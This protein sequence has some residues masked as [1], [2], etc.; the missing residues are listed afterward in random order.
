MR[1]IICNSE[2][3]LVVRVPRPVAAAGTVLVRVHHS[4]ISVG[5]EVA[6]LRGGQAAG[7]SEPPETLPAR[8]R[9]YVAY[10]IADPRAASRR[11]LAMARSRAATYQARRGAAGGRGATGANAATGEAA[12]RESAGDSPASALSPLDRV[13]QGWNVG[14]SVAGR[15]VA[16]GREVAGFAVGDRVACVGAGE[17]NHAD[18]VSVRQRMVCKVPAGCSLELAG[19]AAIGGIAL[20]GVRRAAPQLGETVCVIGLGL[21]GQLTAQLLRAA[22]C[23]VIGMD[24]SAERVQRAIDLGL[25]SGASSDSE[26]LDAVRNASSSHGADLTLI[27]AATKSDTVINLAMDATR[28]KGRVVIVGDVGMNVQRPAFYRKELDLLM[29][30]SYGP[31]RY[32]SGF[33]DEGNDYPYA[34]VR[35]TLTRNVRAY[36]E[37][38]A[39]QH[40]DVAALIDRRIDVDNA[41]D[42]YAELAAADDDVPI[43]V[44]LSFTDD[45]DATARD[46]SASL[47]SLELRPG[48]KVRGGVLR[49]ALVGA[50]AFGTSMLVPQMQ[51]RKD[52]FHLRSVVSRD[53]TRGGNY[54]RA[55]GVEVFTTDLAEVLADPDVELVV[56]A[57]RHHEHAAQA[58]E[59]LE[60]GKHVF[61][62]KP[63]AL[64]WEE[65]ERTVATYEGLAERPLLMVGFNRRFAPAMLKLAECLEGRTGPL[66]MSYRVNA[67]YIPPE[68]WIQGAH[69]GG[70]NLGEACHFYDCF[71]ALAG[72][73][74]RSV[75]ATPINPDALPFKRNDNFQAT[76]SYEDGSIGTLTYTAMGP[77]SGLGKEYLE[78]FCDGEAYVLDDYVSLR[79]CSDGAILWQ[80]DVADKGHFEELS[81]FGDAIAAGAESPIPFGQL[82]ETS[83]AALDIEDLLLGRVAADDGD[84]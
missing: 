58:C 40:L 81:R 48:A 11:A 66:V 41:H 60:A 75:V 18:Y 7:G 46:I 38:I 52:R 59:A 10:S 45:A 8:L 28:R 57:T 61:V 70:R 2:G 13:A 3:A 15:I 6:P 29:S 16:V 24:L 23:K 33:E 69:G 34:Y 83:A 51:R 62:E 9:R 76:L 47:T 37:L 1:Q 55:N 56:I 73:P 67:G 27:T 36:L 19:S 5:T 65:L 22:G 50:G 71:R 49:F 17:A 68:H 63:L 39:S 42:A 32:D 72:A 25:D 77:K 35:W 54:A 79:R 64:S 80:Q 53:T 31:G 30:T 21:I 14:Y 74:I 43:G 12:V 82:I 44:V 26:M 20:Q 84:E 78:V 4:W